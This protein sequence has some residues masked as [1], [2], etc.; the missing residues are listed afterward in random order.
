MLMKY[1]NNLIVLKMDQG[2]SFLSNTL[3]LWCAASFERVARVIACALALWVIPLAHATASGV[4]DHRCPTPGC[5]LLAD[6][7]YTGVL[8]GQLESI[9]SEKQSGFLLH[10]V[11]AQGRWAELSA[12]SAQFTRRIQPVVMRVPNGAGGSLRVIA[13]MSMDEGRAM[14]LQTGDL[15]R[16]R[17]HGPTVSAANPPPEDK[18]ELSYWKAV[19]CVTALCRAGD[20]DCQATYLQ[21]AWRFADGQPIELLSTTP[22]DRGRKIDPMTYFPRP[23]AP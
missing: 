11:Q 7:A 20:A 17:P 14:P 4:E 12:D 3:W 9:L 10:A 19:G 23:E 8:I 1:F 6:G 15:V 2:R 13:L 18:V 16:F 21:G 5:D 22:L